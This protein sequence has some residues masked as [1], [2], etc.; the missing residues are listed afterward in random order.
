MTA[1]FRRDVAD[2][3][4]TITLTRDDKRNAIDFEMWAALETAVDDLATDHSLGVLVIT[5]EGRYFTSGMDIM[6][7]TPNP[8]M[9]DDGV[10]RGSQTRRVYRSNAHH[11]FFDRIEQVEKPIILAAQ[12]HCFGVGVEMGASCDFRFAADVTTFSLPEIANLS[13]LPASGGMSRLTRLIGPHWTKWIAMAGETIDAQQAL[14][15]GFVHA[16]Y[17]AAEFSEKVQAF[18]KRLASSHRE[19]LGLAKLAIDTATEVDRRTAR[20]FDR[21]S[22]TLLFHSPEFQARVKAFGERSANKPASS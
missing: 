9:G 17:P 7:L 10:L 6:T 1:H 8:G 20:D 2:G 11:D 12:N 14:A 4:L 19:A 5:G 22:Q 15:M 3:V 21:L 18:A 13:A 16:V